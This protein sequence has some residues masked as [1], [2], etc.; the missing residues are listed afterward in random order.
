MQVLPIKEIGQI[1]FKNQ[2]TEEE[3]HGLSGSSNGDSGKLKQDG[4]PFFHPCLEDIARV[5]FMTHKVDVAL[6]EAEKIPI[7]HL[8][9]IITP[10]PNC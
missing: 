7:F 5:N 6:H 9:D 1:L 10:P 2:I 4:D 3:V 8:P